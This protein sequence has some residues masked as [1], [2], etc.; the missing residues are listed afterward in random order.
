MGKIC[1][2]KTPAEIAGNRCFSSSLHL[3]SR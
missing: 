1:L 3:S 2:N